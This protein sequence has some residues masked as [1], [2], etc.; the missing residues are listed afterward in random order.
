M[1]IYL[2]ELVYKRHDNSMLSNYKLGFED[3][4]DMI[5]SGV[6]EEI[7]ISEENSW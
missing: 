6:A 4:L 3:A 7:L 5:Y 2:S 1:I